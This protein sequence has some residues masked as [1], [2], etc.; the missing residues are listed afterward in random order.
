MSLTEYAEEVEAAVGAMQVRI[1]S[2]DDALAEPVTSMAEYEAIWRERADARRE[3]LS[4]IE[5]FDPPNEAAALHNAAADIVGRLALAEAAVADQ[6]NDY[7]ALPELNGL[8]TTPAFR[9][10]LDVNEEATNVC[11]AAQGLFDETAQREILAEVS[12][13]TAEMK[14]V[15]EVVFDCVPSET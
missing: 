6:V 2:T 4:V 12:W 8:G 7:E 11:L 5:E 15:I 13:I 3:F 1:L 10:F 14:E 9:G